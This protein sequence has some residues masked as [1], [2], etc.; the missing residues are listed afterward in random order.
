MLSWDYAHDYQKQY[1]SEHV[2]AA[3]QIVINR[4]KYYLKLILKLYISKN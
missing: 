1:Y 3:A 2:Y 4:R